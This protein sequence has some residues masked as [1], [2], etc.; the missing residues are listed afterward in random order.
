MEHTIVGNL[1]LAL[2]SLYIFWAFFFGLVIWIQ[3]ENMREGYPLED[4]AGKVS[5]GQG[6]YGLPSPKTFKL[7]DG[8]GEVT[9]PDPDGGDKRELAM[10]PLSD[11]PGSPYVPTGNPLVDGIG[12]AAW[13]ERR[14][15]PELDG[16][17][18]PKIQ[19]MSGSEFQVVAGR[20]ARGLPVCSADNK[21]VGT[22]TDMWVDVPEQLIRYVEYELTGGGKRLI[23]IQ[24]AN[25]KRDR[26]NVH[27][28]YAEHFEAVPAIKG[29]NQIT[30]LEEEKV[31]AYYCGGKLYAAENREEPQL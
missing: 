24:L 27:S 21:V 20:D 4:D 3:R 23:P 16:H 30:L 10:E 7:R 12:P 5:S 22:V 17:G 18:H 31:C 15:V 14:D 19:P 9:V 8:R 26:I 29:T 2:V 28:L 13:A 1:D 25:F 11:S 6:V